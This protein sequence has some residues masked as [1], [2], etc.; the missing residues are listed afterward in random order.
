MKDVELSVLSGMNWSVNSFG[1][2][3]VADIVASDSDQQLFIFRT[4]GKLAARNL[5]DMQNELKY[6]EQKQEEL[7][8][9]AEFSTDRVLCSAL[10]SYDDFKK[11]IASHAG[12][13]MRQ[14]LQEEI[15]VKLD[16][17]RTISSRCIERKK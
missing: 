13:Q 3:V 5:L 2:A 15:E 16:K 7:D 17:Y 1:L 8:N 14:K 6:L 9:E 4:F 10:R 12:L 11:H